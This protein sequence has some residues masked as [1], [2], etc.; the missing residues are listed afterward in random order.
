MRQSCPFCWKQVLIH[1]CVAWPKNRGSDRLPDRLSDRLPN[2]LVV[3]DSAVDIVY[4]V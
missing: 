3:Y 4:S 1:A 2:R